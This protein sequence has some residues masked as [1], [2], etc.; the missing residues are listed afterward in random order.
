MM[1]TAREIEALA[2]RLESRARSNLLNDQPALQADLLLAARLI[3]TW[4]DEHPFQDGVT[5][6]DESG[7]TG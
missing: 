1:V 4:M 6:D 5:L 2:V 3:F 7:A